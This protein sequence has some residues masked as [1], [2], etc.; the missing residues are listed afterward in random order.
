MDGVMYEA[1]LGRERE[2]ERRRWWLE[3][4]CQ[5]GD[6]SEQVERW[7]PGRLSKLFSFLSRHYAV[8]SFYL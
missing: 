3:R 7:Q 1:T 6:E 8:E 4:Q 5:L 2:L